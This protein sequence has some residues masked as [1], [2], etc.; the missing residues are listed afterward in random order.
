MALNLC[1]LLLASSSLV[2]SYKTKC[3]TERVRSYRQHQTHPACIF[4]TD[5][6]KSTGEGGEEELPKSFE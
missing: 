3:T 4:P 2:V 5:A 1:V 6:S